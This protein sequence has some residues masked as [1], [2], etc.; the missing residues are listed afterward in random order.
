MHGP[1]TLCTAPFSL[2]AMAKGE[3]SPE[4][5]SLDS[6]DDVD[7][8]ISVH[9]IAKL[10]YSKAKGRLLKCWLHLSFPKRPKISSSF[11]TEEIER[12]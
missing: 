11:G 12:V 6:K 8:T 1:Q 10:T 4:S 3:F 7:A 2:Q 5:S 9:D